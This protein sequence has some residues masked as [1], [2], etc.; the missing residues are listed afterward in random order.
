MIH[1]SIMV[2]HIT[3]HY[4]FVNLTYFI[5][6]WEYF[7]RGIVEFDFHFIKI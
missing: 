1:T 6:K 7:A 2:K 3:W 4:N 5:R